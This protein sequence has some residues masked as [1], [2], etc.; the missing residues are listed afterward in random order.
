MCLK[1]S[2]FNSSGP[3]DFFESKPSSASFTL[4]KQ[5]Q[6]VKLFSIIFLSI[7]CSESYGMCVISVAFLKWVSSRALSVSSPASVHSPFSLSNTVTSFL[8]FLLSI[9]VSLLI[10]FASLIPSIYRCQ[11]FFLSLLHFFL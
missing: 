5:I 4:S 11:E 1:I 8:S 9:L 6:S 7:F 2:G 3:G 10:S